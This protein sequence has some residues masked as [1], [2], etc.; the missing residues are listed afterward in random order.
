MASQD[1]PKRPDPLEAYRRAV[2]CSFCESKMRDVVKLIPD[3]GKFICGHCYQDLRECLDDS[4]EF[5]CKACNRRHKLLEKGFADCTQLLDLLRHPIEKPLSPQAEKLKHLIETVQEEIGRAN[6][7]DSK[8]Y[9]DEHCERLELEVCKAAQSAVKHI[10]ELERGL[11][12]QIEE[13]RRRSL[14]GEVSFKNDQSKALVN[15]APQMLNLE[16]L[17]KEINQFATKWTEYFQQINSYATDKEI[18]VALGQGELFQSRIEYIEQEMR[19]SALENISRLQFNA[20]AAFLS[21]SDHLGELVEISIQGNGVTSKGELSFNR[22][23][24]MTFTTL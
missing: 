18:E 24:E 12:K 17:S 4:G 5:E 7:L 19:N 11:L 8:Q 23:S 13:Y 21:Q 20:K 16:A 22:D 1:A 14:D 10:Q 6:A 15:N 3:C 9:V 2:T